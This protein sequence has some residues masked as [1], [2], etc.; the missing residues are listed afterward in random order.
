MRPWV[1]G[2]LAVG[3]ALG[4]LYYTYNPPWEWEGEREQRLRRPNRATSPDWDEAW[5]RLAQ[6]H[7]YN[8]HKDLG[9]V[10]LRLMEAMHHADKL[11]PAEREVLLEGIME[12]AEEVG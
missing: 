8:L 1:I 4:L 7:D 10:R 11:P 6:A 9:H 12:L 2:A 5:E 3:G